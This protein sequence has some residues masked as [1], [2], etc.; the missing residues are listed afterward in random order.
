MPGMLT[1]EDRVIQVDEPPDVLACSECMSPLTWIWVFH[2][3]RTI[4]VVPVQGEDRMTFRLHTCRLN[5][6]KS[7]RPWRY[8]QTQSP[9]TARRGARR[10]RAVLAAKRKHKHTEES[11]G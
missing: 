3:G 7:K 2:L 9:D 4:A 11:D 1:E 8:V 6:E 5:E 10:A